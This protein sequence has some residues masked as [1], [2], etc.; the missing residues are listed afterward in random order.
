[1]ERQDES[2]TPLN[3]RATNNTARLVPLSLL[4]ALK[5]LYIFTNARCLAR[6]AWGYPP[7]Y[8]DRRPR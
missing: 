1:M 8:Q 6:T 2:T 5:T 4:Q 3:R 7:F